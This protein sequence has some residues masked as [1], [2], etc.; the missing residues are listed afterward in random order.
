MIDWY[1]HQSGQGRIGPLDADTLRHFY[2]QRRIDLQT[3]AWHA[4]LREW[5]PLERLREELDLDGVQPDASQPPPLPPPSITGTL[6]TALPNHPSPP[7]RRNNGCLIAAI[8]TAAAGVLLLPIVA[9]IALPAYNNYVER[10]RQAQI[11]G[12]RLRDV[13]RSARAQL[14][15]ALAR[16]AQGQAPAADARCPDPGTLGS[17]H[18]VGPDREADGSTDVAF[19]FERAPPASGTCAYTLRFF[20]FPPAIDAARLHYDVDLTRSTIVIACRNQDLPA[21]LLPASC[22]P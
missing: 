5:Q 21:Y 14:Y 15:A 7:A 10:S 16:E 20:G 2:R 4:G 12:E 11:D 18:V 3:L 8:V 9:A 1:C 17:A 19:T 6:A 22:S 13:E